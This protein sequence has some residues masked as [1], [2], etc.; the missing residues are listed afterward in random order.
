MNNKELPLI[1]IGVASYNNE[2]FI[3]ETL[4]SIK[5]QD[6]KNIELII[7]DDYSSD[8]SCTVIEKW[9][10]TYNGYFKFI[11]SDNNQGICMVFNMILENANGDCIS[12]IGSDDTIEPSKISKQIELFNA[13][14]CA[15][16]SNAYLITESSEKLSNLCIENYRRFFD[17]PSGIIYDILMDGN[18]IPIMSVLFKKSALLEIGGFNSDLDYEDYDA[19]L[20]L[21]RIGN[22]CYS[23]YV[24]ASYRQR[25][26]SLSSR[27]DWELNNLKI[28]RQHITFSDKAKRNIEQIFVISLENNN[29]RVISEIKNYRQISSKMYAL[30]LISKLKLSN[31]IVLRILRHYSRIF[32]SLKLSR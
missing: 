27:I 21:S 4:E 26:N 6:Y 23:D 31:K 29:S 9:L 28:F 16:Y 14:V 15:V 13:D 3:I 22:I 25:S 18:F 8:N 11:R 32:Q 12:F 19:L 7:V 20:K 1:T 2:R 30:Y 5:A 24:S 10:T 17:Y